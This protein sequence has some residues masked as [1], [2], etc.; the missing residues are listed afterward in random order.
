MMCH[1]RRSEE[2]P[3]RMDG[4]TV[5]IFGPK[6]THAIRARCLHCNMNA[7]VRKDRA[8]CFRTLDN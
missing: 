4:D 3:T 5:Y 6:Q 2:E 8:G 7:T 1:S